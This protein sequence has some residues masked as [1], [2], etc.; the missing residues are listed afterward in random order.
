VSTAIALL[1]VVLVLLL[2]ALVRLAVR[3]LI[4]RKLRALAKGDGGARLRREAEAT[5]LRLLPLLERRNLDLA[6]RPDQ[7]GLR[8]D[9][10]A[11]RELA[12]FL[13]LRRALRWR[14]Y[15]IFGPVETL[16]G[17]LETQ[18]DGRRLLRDAG[19]ALRER[20]SNIASRRGFQNLLDDYTLAFGEPPDPA[21]WRPP[22]TRENRRRDGAHVV[23]GDSAQ[24][25][26]GGE[27]GLEGGDSGGG[28]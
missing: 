27:G 10:A 22:P 3:S 2:P 7:S 28:D 23:G 25:F 6:G 13:L 5:A 4:A 17:W 24:V 16:W 18:D 14:S 8:I 12:R 21:L 11:A 15:R 1:A 26:L 19:F 20:H 9:P